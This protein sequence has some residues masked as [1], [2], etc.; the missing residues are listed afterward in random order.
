MNNQG[1]TF[2]HVATGTWN[3]KTET[4]K[5]SAMKAACRTRK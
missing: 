3:V 1:A 4:M 5:A 2:S